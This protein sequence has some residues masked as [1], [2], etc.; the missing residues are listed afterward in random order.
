MADGNARAGLRVPQ[1]FYGLEGQSNVVA[2]LNAL[3]S[4]LGDVSDPRSAWFLAD[5]LMTYGHTRGFLTD[6]RFV[7]AV[8]AAA[9]KP[10]ER[11]LAW[12][13]HTMC[14]A[15]QSCEKL[16]G[17]FVE[18]GTYE[19]YTM[20]VVLHYLHGLPGRRLWLYD[21][22]NPTGAAGEGKPMPEHSPRLYERVRARFERW[23]NVTVTRG[24]VPDIL[25]TVAP[26]R[27]AFLHIDMNNAAAEL[28]A[29]ERLFDRLVTGGIVVLDDYG[30]TGYRD[31]KAA[32]DV[33]AAARG[34]S[35]LELPTG[36]GMLLKR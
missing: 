23:P 21:L 24:K 33:F 30:W 31:Q 14:W 5:N 8:V 27:I 28:G 29:M 20:E 15:A 13:T 6:Q 3:V 10:M 12:R 9:P 25:A 11:G 2:R 4:E 22:F 34:L 35:V 26:E 17:D 16:D 7:A 18:C 1:I 19:G 36:Q 32:A